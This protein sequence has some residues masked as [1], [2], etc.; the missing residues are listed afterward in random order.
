MAWRGYVP[1]MAGVG[2]NVPSEETDP[3]GC[4]GAVWMHGRCCSECQQQL[5]QPA[6]VD[7]W[8]N[9]EC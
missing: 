2:C 6:V 9:M 7:A 1:T 4:W 3:G 5:E 8:T